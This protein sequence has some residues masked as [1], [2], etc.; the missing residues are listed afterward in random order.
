MKYDVVIKCHPLN[1]RHCKM[2]MGGSFDCHAPLVGR[3][4]STRIGDHLPDEGE[5]PS[6]CPLPGL[7]DTDF[8]IGYQMDVDLGN[9]K[10][11][12]VRQ[13]CIRCTNMEC[14]AK[15]RDIIRDDDP[16]WY[17]KGFKE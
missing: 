16:P 8:N 2:N 10:A 1:C 7:K 11:K 5:F 4:G 6:I 15:K 17:C 12:T 13:S 14:S 9:G 3:V